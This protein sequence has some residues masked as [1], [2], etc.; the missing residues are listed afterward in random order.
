MLSILINKKNDINIKIIII[1]NDSGQFC[2]KINFRR[3]GKTV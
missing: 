1:I 3:L 2:A